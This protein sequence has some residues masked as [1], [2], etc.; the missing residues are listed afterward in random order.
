MYI[1]AGGQ[2]LSNQFSAHT[3][4][5]YRIALGICNIRQSTAKAG[6]NLKGQ[7]QFFYQSAA[8]TQRARAHI[9]SH[10]TGRNPLL[11]QIGAHI[12]VVAANIRHRAAG[13]HHV[14]H[15]LQSRS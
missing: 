3:C 5:N 12:A 2:D 13:R 15:S 1:R 4:Q 14:R 10:H 11:H 9:G 8:G 7:A 6:L